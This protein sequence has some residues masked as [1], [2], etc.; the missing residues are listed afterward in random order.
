MLSS[1]HGFPKEFHLP[2]P[3]D[4]ARPAQRISVVLP[5]LLLRVCCERCLLHRVVPNL[6]YL[7]LAFETSFI[8][9]LGEVR[10]SQIYRYSAVSHSPLLFLQVLYLGFCEPIPRFSKSSLQSSTQVRFMTIPYL[11]CARMRLLHYLPKTSPYQINSTL[12]AQHTLNESQPFIFSERKAAYFRG[13]AY[14]L[15][16]TKCT[17]PKKQED[18][19]SSSAASQTSQAGNQ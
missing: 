7:D 8:S 10:V 15:R 12:K 14:Y 2:R 6:G 9:D 3:D 13:F 17:D 18:S 19:R 16:R 11:C 4:T 1:P 5:S